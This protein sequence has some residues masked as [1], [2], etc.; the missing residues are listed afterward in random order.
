MYLEQIK[1]DICSQCLI[2]LD[3]H[4]TRDLIVLDSRRQ[5]IVLF[6]WSSKHWQVLCI[7]SAPWYLICSTCYWWN[8]VVFIWHS[9]RAYIDIF[10]GEKKEKWIVVLSNKSP[11]IW[12]MNLHNC[13][14]P[15]LPSLGAS[16]SPI[17]FTCL[18]LCPWFCGLLAYLC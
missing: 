4:K 6:W 16:F 11:C 3:W 15:A 10:K 14:F 7:L 1:V 5:F 9:I 13:I 8:L 12:L 2:W 18:L 17:Y